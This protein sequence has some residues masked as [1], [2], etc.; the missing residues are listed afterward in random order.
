MSRAALTEPEFLDWMQH[1]VTRALMQILHDK[2]EDL[3]QRWESGAFTDYEK[4]ATV[5][6]N[7]G[8]LGTCKG[9]A[10]VTEFTYEQ[11]ITEIDDGESQRIGP[12]GGSSADQ[13]VRTGAER[14]PDSAS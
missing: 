4:E 3:R 9:Y 7:V 12:S 14:G 11:Y 2:R 8:N 13:S 5:L 6:V 1:P 10:F